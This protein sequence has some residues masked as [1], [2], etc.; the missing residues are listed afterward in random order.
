MKAAIGGVIAFTLQ[1]RQAMLSLSLCG[2][3]GVGMGKVCGDAA[4]RV[5]VTYYVQVYHG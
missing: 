3:V 1:I 5:R 4:D 2:W